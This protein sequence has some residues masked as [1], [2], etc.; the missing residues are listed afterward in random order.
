MRELVGVR[1]ISI[2]LVAILCA[3]A[4]ASDVDNTPETPSSNMMVGVDAGT[5]PEPTLDAGT[6][7]QNRE[8]DLTQ[9]LDTI[10]N[11]T[12][13]AVYRCCNENDKF[14]FGIHLRRILPWKKNLR[15]NYL[16]EM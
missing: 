6:E 11:E 13:D 16:L 1:N 14:N 15:V 2:A 7:P 4:D 10:V 8:T 9:L 3:C 5:T 12:C